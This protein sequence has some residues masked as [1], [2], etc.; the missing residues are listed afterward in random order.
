ML[1]TIIQQQT[2]SRTGS[3]LAGPLDQWD[4]QSTQCTTRRYHPPPP[5]FALPA[6]PTIHQSPPPPPTQPQG[7][8]TGWTPTHPP[9]GS[10]CSPSFPPSPP[11]AGL[12]TSMVRYTSPTQGT[13]TPPAP[14]RPIT[15]S[16][17]TTPQSL[18]FHEDAEHWDAKP[19]FGLKL[20]KRVASTPYSQKAGISGRP[21]EQVPVMA[22]IRH[23]WSSYWLRY[24]SNGQEMFPV[25]SKSI[26]DAVLASEL[27]SM[28]R[29]RKINA[30]AAATAYAWEH[31]LPMDRASAVKALAE[32][33][34][35]YMEDLIHKRQVANNASN[36]A[37]Q[38]MGTPAAVQA[39][40]Q[41]ANPASSH[42]ITQLEVQLAKAQHTIRRTQ[43]NAPGQA[44]LGPGHRATGPTEA[45][46]ST[47][48]EQIDRL[49]QEVGPP[50]PIL[51]QVTEDEVVEIPESIPASQDSVIFSPSGRPMLDRDE[52]SPAETPPNPTFTSP[53][54]TQPTSGVTTSTQGTEASA[55]T[56]PPPK[57][58][59]QATL[60]SPAN[61]HR[62]RDRQARSST[63][64]R[65]PRHGLLPTIPVFTRSPELFAGSGALNSPTRR[66]MR[67]VTTLKQSCDNS[68]ASARNKEAILTGT[69]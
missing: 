5:I 66:R 12:P 58:L 49:T 32:D 55:S 20:L 27:L 15:Q 64:P 41:G 59:R 53:S 23:G 3:S 16:R 40:A 30:D 62:Q 38:T 50:E 52:P 45:R 4:L 1:T 60:T 7:S 34:C 42:R 18:G 63:P 36:S 57:R 25:M 46:G 11:S 51:P 22:I 54:N 26:A 29:Q 2:C 9:P 48:Q 24:L 31:S 17:M 35:D 65:S 19:K 47:I 6:Q 37:Q 28:I 43:T 21:I 33:F 8:L 69:Q 68:P 44:S 14:S 61:Q 67:C 39:A 56:R 10:F 13:F